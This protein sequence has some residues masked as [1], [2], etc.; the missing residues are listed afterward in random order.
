MG[1]WGSLVIL[2]AHV[3]LCCGCRR[4]D[5]SAFL[6]LSASG[7]M[8]SMP[9]KGALCNTNSEMWQDRQ[10]CAVLSETVSTQCGPGVCGPIMGPQCLH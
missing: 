1:F 8:L 5:G 7:G 10:E 3:L 2:G 4:H 6:L 9:N